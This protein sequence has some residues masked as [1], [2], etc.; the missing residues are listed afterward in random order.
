MQFKNVKTIMDHSLEAFLAHH[1]VLL[2]EVP[3]SRTTCVGE[4]LQDVTKKTF[5]PVRLDNL[6]C[7]GSFQV[8][9]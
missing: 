1:L 7:A 9:N 5:T 3:S 6:S 4:I 2:N 8:I